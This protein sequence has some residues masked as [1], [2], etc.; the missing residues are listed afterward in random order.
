MVVRTERCAR[1]PDTVGAADWR[2]R[3][4]MSEPELRHCG[5]CVLGPQQS[6]KPM[7][8]IDL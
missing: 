1:C 8:I 4:T 7:R 6:C 3:M 5:S 2:L